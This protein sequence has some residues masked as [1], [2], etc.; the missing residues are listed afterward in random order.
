M[1]NTYRVMQILKPGILQLAER[2]CP[3]PGKGSCHR[4]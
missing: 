3:E 4:R 2:T 1:T